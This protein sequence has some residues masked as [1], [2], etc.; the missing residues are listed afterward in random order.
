MLTPANY[1]DTIAISFAIATI[2]YYHYKQ[3]RQSA[4]PDKQAEEPAV[5]IVLR[6]YQLQ[7][8]GQ[9]FR[10]DVINNPVPT[11]ATIQQCYKPITRFITVDNSGTPILNGTEFTIPDFQIDT[12]TISKRLAKEAV[13]KAYD[14]YIRKKVHDEDVARVYDARQ[15]EIAAGE[16]I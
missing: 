6:S 3:R 14:A 10:V 12:P 2:A 15:R 1:F 13:E 8:R 5:P 4:K 16:L 11:P 9:L 7:L